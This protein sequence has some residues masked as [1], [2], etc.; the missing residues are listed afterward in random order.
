MLMGKFIFVGMNTSLIINQRVFS[1][2]YEKVVP[3]AANSRTRIRYI[4]MFMFIYGYL[5]MYIYVK[6]C[7]YIKCTYIYLY[8]PLVG[9]F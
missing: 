1:H 3:I 2:G 7:V 8:G 6:M 4:Y 9:A 5:Y